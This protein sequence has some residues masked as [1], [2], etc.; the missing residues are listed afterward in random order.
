M[1]SSLGN[2]LGLKL[3]DPDRTVV[4]VCGDGTLSMSGMEIATAATH[5]LDIVYAVF[6][7]FRY[8]MVEEGCK[9]IYGRTHAFPVNLSIADFAQSIGARS[10]VVERAGD[11]FTLGAGDLIGHDRP[12]ILDIRID[13][14]ERMPRRARFDSIKNFIASSAPNPSHTT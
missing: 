3:A 1:G 6:N 10:F 11:I 7:D 4:A 13:P 12:T 14:T 5:G 2:A 8:G 9:A